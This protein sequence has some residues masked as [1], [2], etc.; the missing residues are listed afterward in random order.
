VLCHDDVAPALGQ[1][2]LFRPHNVGIRL[3]RFPGMGGVSFYSDEINFDWDE[4]NLNHNVSRTEAEQV[5]FNGS[6]EI[7][8]QG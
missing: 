3:Q 5:I 7:S 4:T 6:V 8:Y 1:S 2:S